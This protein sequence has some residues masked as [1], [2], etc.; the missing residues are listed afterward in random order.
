MTTNPYQAP[1]ADINNQ[2]TDETY[3]PKIFS[4]SGR[5]GRL[6]Y[7]AYSLIAL[8]FYVPA[9]IALSLGGLNME[10]G[11]MTMLG[12]IG[13]GISAVLAVVWMFVIFKRRF[14]DI[15]LT[16]WLS[17]LVLVPLIGGIV[18]IVLMFTPGTKTAN[19]Y[20]PIPE[21]NSIGV[22]VAAGALILLM[23]GSIVAAVMLP[24]LI[25]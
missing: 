4:V 1:S 16:G 24:F 5:I 6:R 19:K 2:K 7:L 17:L 20:G 18:T 21:Q 10:T 9:I 22:K 3:S 11:D 25:Q 8:I 14:N 12:G 23:V 15:N 13:F